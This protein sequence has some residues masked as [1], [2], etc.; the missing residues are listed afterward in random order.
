MAWCTL[1]VDSYTEGHGG[2]VPSRRY[3]AGSIRGGHYVFALV[4]MAVCL[5]QSSWRKIK[6]PWNPHVSQD[7]CTSCREQG[8]EELPLLSS[9]RGSPG[10]NSVPLQPQGGLENGLEVPE[11]H[12]DIWGIRLQAAL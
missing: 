5:A 3:H 7:R 8:L 11:V 2:C 9:C 12:L 6:L 1:V 10:D 4:R